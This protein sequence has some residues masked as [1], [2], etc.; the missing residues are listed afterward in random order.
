M[1]YSYEIITP[2]IYD[3]KLKIY[4]E[5]SDDELD[6]EE[7]EKLLSIEVSNLMEYFYLN[8][9]KVEKI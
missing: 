3:S 4:L 9:L 6:I 5:T 7:I 8:K 1:K 2:K